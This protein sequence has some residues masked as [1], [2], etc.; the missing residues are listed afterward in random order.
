MIL[1]AHLSHWMDAM[2]RKL[3]SISASIFAAVTVLLA[4]FSVIALH[5]K[6]G[7]ATPVAG[8]PSARPSA[9]LITASRVEVRPAASLVQQDSGQL[10]SLNAGKPTA[11]SLGTTQPVRTAPPGAT[12]HTVAKGE[13]LPGIVHRYLPLTHFM[14][15]SELE[16]AIRATNPGVKGISPTGIWPKPG[17]EL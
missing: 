15:G 13:S 4:T 16:S 3:L 14:T 12:L 9:A 5:S 6:A 7:H 11:G 10:A 8:V 17:S 2:S 1:S